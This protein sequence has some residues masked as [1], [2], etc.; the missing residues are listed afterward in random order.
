VPRSGGDFE[1]EM[2]TAFVHGA[3][4]PLGMRTSYDS[5]CH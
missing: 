3:V 2:L 4:C 5:A 1:H